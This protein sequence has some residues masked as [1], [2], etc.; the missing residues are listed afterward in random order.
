MSSI[1]RCR[2][3]DVVRDLGA[4][5]GRLSPSRVRGRSPKWNPAASYS[6][7]I[8]AFRIMA[9]MFKVSTQEVER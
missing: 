8:S 2:A 5:V 3:V 9:A 7:M 6:S 4:L 1:E